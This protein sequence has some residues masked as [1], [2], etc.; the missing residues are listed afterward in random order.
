MSKILF[1][2]RMD[3]IREARTCI[4]P[5]GG[6][7]RM[8]NK[9]ELEDLI[10]RVDAIAHYAPSWVVNKVYAQILVALHCLYAWELLYGE[11]EEEADG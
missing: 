5:S 8:F 2:Q 1:N 4:Y 10:S 3:N 7:C 9:E 11:K 6:D